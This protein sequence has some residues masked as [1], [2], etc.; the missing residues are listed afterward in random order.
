MNIVYILLLFVSGLIV[1]VFFYAGLKLTVKHVIMMKRRT[2]WFLLS[3]L[4]RAAAAIA[5]ILLISRGRWPDVLI[6]MAGFVAARFI[7]VNLRR[8]KD[9]EGETWADESDS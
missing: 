5:A 6:V 1:G 2:T 9:S 7:M 3:F 8:R 4:F